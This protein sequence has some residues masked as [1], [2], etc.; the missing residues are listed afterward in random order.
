M[1]AGCESDF[2][3]LDAL[4]THLNGPA[5]EDC[6][7]AKENLGFVLAIICLHT[8]VGP[9]VNRGMPIAEVFRLL[10]HTSGGEDDTIS[11]SNTASFD[12]TD[13]DTWVESATAAQRRTIAA[14]PD[15]HRT[16]Q[17]AMQDERARRNAAQA[18][19]DTIYR[20]T[21]RLD[22]V[23]VQNRELR[24]RLLQ[25]EQPFLDFTADSMF[26]EDGDYGLVAER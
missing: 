20:L 11:S 21:A 10:L 2:V 1:T 23:E 22:D 19:Q 14:S 15:V 25:Q 6:R 18:Q 5:G 9:Y 12:G 4:N 13:F 16:I 17:Q 26:A 8:V 3:R 24:A 7:V